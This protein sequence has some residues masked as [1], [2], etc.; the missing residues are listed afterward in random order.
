MRKHPRILVPPTQ[1]QFFLSKF[2]EPNSSMVE[3]FVPSKMIVFLKIKPE[4]L[5]RQVRLIHWT[6]FS[7]LSMC[8]FY[9][10]FAIFSVRLRG[11]PYYEDGGRTL[12]DFQFSVLSGNLQGSYSLIFLKC[13]I[14]KVF[15]YLHFDLWLYIYF[16]Q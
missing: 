2:L 13:W 9:L 12:C 10:Y 4:E 8:R 11:V 5:P 6:L 3:M 14:T 15:G 16:K 7:Q 1:L